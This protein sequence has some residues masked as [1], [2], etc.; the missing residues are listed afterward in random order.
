MK[1]IAKVLMFVFV[2]AGAFTLSLNT[3]KAENN[4]EKNIKVKLMN[5]QVNTDT[6]EVIIRI[7]NNTSKTIKLK[8]ATLSDDK[9]LSI[10]LSEKE[11]KIKKGKTKY[12]NIS[13]NQESGRYRMDFI[14][15]KE[16]TVKTIKLNVKEIKKEDIKDD[17]KKGDKKPV[18][19]KIDRVA[20]DEIDS[21]SG[22]TLGLILLNGNFRIGKNGKSNVVIFSENDFKNTYK[23]K[24]KVMI[25][26]KTKKGFKVCKKFVKREKSNIAFLNKTFS[27]KKKGKYK[28][29][30]KITR[31]K[32]ENKKTVK[33]TSTY[34]SKIVEYK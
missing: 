25:K 31:Y 29:V 26:Q 33:E 28:M 3:A 10:N 21:P 22:N 32:K 27:L 17:N 5:S 6:T 13:F 1:K 9:D 20:K 14:F 2:I 19:V 15:N 23:T 4:N 11:I 34:T 7:K 30:V 8:K 12:L 16:K 24:I 18:D